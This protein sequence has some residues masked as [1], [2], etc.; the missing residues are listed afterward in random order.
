MS[1]IVNLVCMRVA[2]LTKPYVASE[3]SECSV[4]DQPVWISKT[5][6]GIPGNFVVIC[7]PCAIEAADGHEPEVML[8]PGQEK[9]L[10]S[11]YPNMDRKRLIQIAKDALSGSRKDN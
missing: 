6:S 7:L 5:I 8:L 2:D 3:Q 11:K 10:T 9:E 4:C 1:D